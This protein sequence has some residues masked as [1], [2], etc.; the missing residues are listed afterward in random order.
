MPYVKRERRG[1]VKPEV[2]P[3]CAGEL[4]YTFTKIVIDYI[5]RKGENYQTYNDCIGAL[6]GAKQ[7]LYRRKVSAYE[8]LK[9][10]ENGD[11]YDC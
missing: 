6:E 5:A 9:A 10:Q 2:V 1:E 4:N 7:E 8:T 11:V 3:E